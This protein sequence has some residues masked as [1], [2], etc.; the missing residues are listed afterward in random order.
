[1]VYAMRISQLG[2]QVAPILLTANEPS[3]GA[4]F[5]KSMAIAGDRLLIG[6]PHEKVCSEDRAANAS[7]PFNMTHL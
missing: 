3:G 2:H 1:M 5:G 4:H 6:A 7:S